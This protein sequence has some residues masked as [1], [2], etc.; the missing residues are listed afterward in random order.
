MTRMLA[1]AATAA[2]F[3]ALAATS[4]L[5]QYPPGNPSAPGP[6]RV[7]NPD[8]VLTTPGG[9][10]A[11]EGSGFG[12]GA[13]ICIVKRA[14]TM[15]GSGCETT[16]VTA[17]V[18]SPDAGTR[19][20]AIVSANRQGAFV[21]LVDIADEA[22]AGDVVLAAVGLN[23]AGLVEVRDIPVHIT[24][25]ASGTAGATVVA[26]PTVALAEGPIRGDDAAA[27]AT[28]T[29]VTQSLD[30]QPV[31]AALTMGDGLLIGSLLIG[32]V[33]LLVRGPGRRRRTT[34]LAELT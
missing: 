32:G 7:T 15:I 23:R 22:T 5:A 2:V 14:G 26:T 34:G 6:G 25:R 8:V 13:T 19:P 21:A 33:L 16:S 3:L 1:V 31:M 4:A 27:V 17:A 18:G 10:I 28:P 9:S 12:P 24:E 11:L 30:A 29:V 20:H